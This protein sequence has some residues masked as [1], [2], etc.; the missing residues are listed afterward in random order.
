MIPRKGLAIVQPNPNRTEDSKLL[1]IPTGSPLYCYVCRT[2]ASDMFGKMF[3]LVVCCVA[4]ISND[5]AAT[6]SC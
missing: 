2:N 4:R 6:F 5:H 1:V 3:G